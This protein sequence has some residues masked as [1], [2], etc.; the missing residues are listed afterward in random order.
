MCEHRSLKPRQIIN[1]ERDPRFR[2]AFDR[3]LHQLSLCLTCLTTLESIRYVGMID[4]FQPLQCS[5]ISRVWLP[6]LL[7]R[8]SIRLADQ[9]EKRSAVALAGTGGLIN[10]RLE[11]S[12]LNDVL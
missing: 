5:I 4:G 6:A 12:A 2:C 11:T 8:S 9:I 3:M 10:H 7:Q 1:I